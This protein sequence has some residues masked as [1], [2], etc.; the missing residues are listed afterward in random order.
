MGGLMV[1]KVGQPWL[2]HNSGN[3]LA[4][5]N[6]PYLSIQLLLI[7][8]SNLRSSYFHVST[9]L[10]SVIFSAVLREALMEIYFQLFLKTMQTLKTLHDVK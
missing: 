4:T 3:R 5:Y 6:I 9:Y 7:L 1:V 8:Y 10:F 2:V